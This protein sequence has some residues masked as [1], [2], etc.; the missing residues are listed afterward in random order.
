[1]V[2]HTLQGLP[3]RRAPRSL[4]TRVHS[5]LARRAA[6][7][8]WRRGFAEWPLWARGTF[9]A[10]C[11]GLVSLS[12]LAGAWLSSSG[13]SPLRPLADAV[14]LSMDRR[15]LAW[16]GPISALW[17]AAQVLANALSGAIPSIWLEAGA[18]FAL[19]AYAVLFGSAAMTYRVLRE[20]H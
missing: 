6:L 14:P 16:V 5:E 15:P 3:E 13:H 9:V 20:R 10:L 11:V 19:V 2:D 7:P 8:W 17:N 4:V 12:V 18:A 1:M